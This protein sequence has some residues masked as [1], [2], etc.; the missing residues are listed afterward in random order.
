MTLNH[1]IS[2]ARKEVDARRRTR[3]AGRR[4]APLGRSAEA[5][6]ARFRERSP[7][8]HIAISRTSSLVTAKI[9][10][11]KRA[12]GVIFFHQEKSFQDHCSSLFLRWHPVSRE[13]AEEQ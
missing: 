9:L 6:P 1:L 2:D 7:C 3:E 10:E 11:E 5:G 8:G 13:R 12:S 4:I